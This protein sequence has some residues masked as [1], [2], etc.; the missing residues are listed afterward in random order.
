MALDLERVRENVAAADTEDLLD[1]ATVY[2]DGMEPEALELIDAELRLRGVGE[3]R[4]AAHRARR[5]GSLGAADGLALCCGLPGCSRP[6]VEWRW[7]WNRGWSVMP[8]FPRLQ[9]FCEVHLPLRWQFR[10]PD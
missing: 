7:G 5:A 1:R 4:I 6:A 8:V 2:R 10:H 9:P 3:G